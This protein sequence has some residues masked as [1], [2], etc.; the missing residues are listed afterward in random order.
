MKK[1]FLFAFFLAA[2]GSA[3]A[4]GDITLTNVGQYHDS[5]DSIRFKLVIKDTANKII[6]ELYSENIS[7]QQKTVIFKNQLGIDRGSIDYYI[8]DTTQKTGFRKCLN[9]LNFS[10]S[11]I[12]TIGGWSNSSNYDCNL[13]ED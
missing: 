12:T 11:Y 7:P 6:N 2:T 1:I 5:E 8:E 13:L 10:I 4:Q 9:N 3:L